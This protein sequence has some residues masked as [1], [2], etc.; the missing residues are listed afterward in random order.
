MSE[1]AT[2]KPLPFVIDPAVVAAEKITYAFYH[3]VIYNFYSFTYRYA[4]VLLN[5]P[6]PAPKVKIPP[7]QLPTGWR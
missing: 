2:G 7:P 1:R 6:D 5:S 3:R 4:D